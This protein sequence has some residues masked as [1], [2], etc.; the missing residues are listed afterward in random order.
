MPPGKLFTPFQHAA[1]PAVAASAGLRKSCARGGPSPRGGMESTKTAGR[2][3][4]PLNGE[5]FITRTFLS[6][7]CLFSIRYRHR[8]PE[9]P[10]AFLYPQ[11][12]DR[13][14][15]PWVPCPHP[16]EPPCL[17]SDK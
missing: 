9:S 8:L 14:R 1:L 3:D 12:R 16:L 6:L 10:N 11:S 17:L 5:T 4:G 2:S 15:V 7:F 13:P